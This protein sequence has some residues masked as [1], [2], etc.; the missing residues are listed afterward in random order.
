MKNEERPNDPV[1]TETGELQIALLLLPRLD[2]LVV[3]VPVRRDHAR[4]LVGV[5]VRLLARIGQV[6]VGVAFVIRE[7]VPLFRFEF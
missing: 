5:A 1:S 4:L 2:Q 3:A 7:R 6:A